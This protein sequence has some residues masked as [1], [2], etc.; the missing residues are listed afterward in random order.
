MF[1]NILV[2]GRTMAQFWVFYQPLCTKYGKCG[3]LEELTDGSVKIATPV[4]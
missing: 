1:D 4:G 2:D 3:S